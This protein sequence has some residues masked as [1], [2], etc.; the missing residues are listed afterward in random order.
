MQH[1]RCKQRMG[2]AF[3]H[4]EFKN[5]SKIKRFGKKNKKV[6]G[7]LFFFTAAFT[8]ASIIMITPINVSSVNQCKKQPWLCSIFDVNE[9]WGMHSDTAN[10]KIKPI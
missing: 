1:F 4:W 3:R 9:G 10:L 2:H 6:S 7:L 8:F 5:K